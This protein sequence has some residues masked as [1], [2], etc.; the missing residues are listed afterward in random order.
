M[1]NQY[2]PGC[3]VSIFMNLLDYMVIR[4]NIDDLYHMSVVREKRL[5]YMYAML[6]LALL[7]YMVLLV[8]FVVPLA[9][10]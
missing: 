3:Y 6:V 8:L 1:F 2:R 4:W 5:K 7:D 10:I 9:A